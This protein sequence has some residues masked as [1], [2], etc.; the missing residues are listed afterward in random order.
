MK[1]RISSIAFLA[2]LTFVSVA[3]AHYQ[4]D[5]VDAKESAEIAIACGDKAVEMMKN[6]DFI[7]SVT[8]SYSE[9][10]NGE[11]VKTY[12]FETSRIRGMGRTV[13]GP[14]LYAERVTSPTPPGLECAPPQAKVKNCTLIPPT[15]Q[16]A[17]E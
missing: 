8:G 6:A 11:K 7:K 5:E 9:R 15:P 1:K 17:L 4:E 14:T 2:S 13:N 3:Q 16:E 12:T 10:S